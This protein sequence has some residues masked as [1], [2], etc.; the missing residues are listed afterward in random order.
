MKTR[1][2]CIEILKAH[3]SE[4]KEKFGISYMRIFGSVA[5]TAVMWMWF[6]MW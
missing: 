4:L 3:E 6:L 2:E 5:R 1:Q